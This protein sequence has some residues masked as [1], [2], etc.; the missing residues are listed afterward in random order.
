MKGLYKTLAVGTILAFLAS[1]T[2]KI[3]NTPISIQ[4]NTPTPIVEVVETATEEPTLEPTLKPTDIPTETPTI[5]PTPL[6]ELVGEVLTA[7]GLSDIYFLENII[8]NG[9]EIKVFYSDVG[10]KDSTKNQKTA[11]GGNEWYNATTIDNL[12]VQYVKPDPIYDLKKDLPSILERLQDIYKDVDVNFSQIKVG[13]VYSEGLGVLCQDEDS[14]I[15]DYAVCL[16]QT[17]DGDVII[18]LSQIVHPY[19]APTTVNNNNNNNDVCDG[20]LIEGVCYPPIPTPDQ[21]IH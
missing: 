2:P 9:N 3:E 1:C 17:T 10:I 5:T 11:Q 8:L 4:E 14:N 20:V 12:A 13:G 7:D 16:A 6:P 21:V 19:V 18:L 15:G